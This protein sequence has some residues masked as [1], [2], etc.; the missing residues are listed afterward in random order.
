V[1]QLPNFCSSSTAEHERNQ[2]IKRI[3]KSISLLLATSSKKKV[4]ITGDATRLRRI[5]QLRLN[6]VF[7]YSQ[8]YSY[9]LVNFIMLN[10]FDLKPALDRAEVI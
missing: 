7:L 4:L 1:N 9:W 5:T 10:G 6:V 8:N 2:N 3:F